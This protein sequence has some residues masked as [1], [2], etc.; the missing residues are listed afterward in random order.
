[1]PRSAVPEH[2]LKRD[3]EGTDNASWLMR[4]KKRIQ[5]IFAAGP[6]V[7][8]GFWKWRDIPKCLI[9]LSGDGKVRTENTDGSQIGT[10]PAHSKVHL[11]ALDSAENAHYISR[12]QPWLRWHFS[13]NWPLFVNMHVIYRKRDVEKAPKYQ[14]EFGIKKMLTFGIG[15]KRDADKVYWLTMNMGGNFE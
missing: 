14:S 12:I 3:W 1:M 9:L 11:N 4:M 8:S 6:N 10:L 13:V 5:Y 2:L 7:P 15:A